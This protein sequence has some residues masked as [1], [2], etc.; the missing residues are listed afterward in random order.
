MAAY[1]NAYSRFIALAKIV[2]P[3]AALGLLSTLFLFS[4]NIDPTQSI[5]YAKVDVEQLA[6]EQRITA[7]NY[8][9]VTA[10]GTA[11]SVAAKT[12]HPDV[13]DR[14]RATAVT[15]TAQL[16]FQDGSHTEISA[17]EGQIDTAAGQA[18]LEGGVL[19]TTSTGY[20]ITTESL[21]TALDRTFVSTAGAVTAQGPLGQLDAGQ[22]QLEETGDVPGQY[23]LV[24]KNGVKLVYDPETSGEDK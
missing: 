22:M 14:D 1:D 3:L 16:D 21:T 9:G 17:A 6:R 18:V 24:F 15:L 19:V 13:A 20:R 23:L 5:P 8:T 2:L 4:R 11:I 12:A 7:P 10:D